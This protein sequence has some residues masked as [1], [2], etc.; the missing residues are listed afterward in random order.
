MHYVQSSTV[1]RI[2]IT[3]W[4]ILSPLVPPKCKERNKK[5]FIHSHWYLWHPL[6]PH[7][8]WQVSRTNHVLHFPW[9]RVRHRTLEL[10]QPYNIISTQAS[11]QPQ[12]TSPSLHQSQYCAS[13][14]V[15][16]L[17]QQQL[18]HQTIKMLFIRDRILPILLSHPDPFIKDMP[19]LH[20]VLRE[21]NSEQAKKNSTQHKCLP[22]ITSYHPAKKVLVHNPNNFDNNY[23]M[24]C[25]S[26]LFLWFLRSG[27]ITILNASAYDPPVHLKF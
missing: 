16:H 2:L 12:G 17:A 13:L 26:A 25:F 20:Y 18:K 6:S 8:D 9:N 15:S 21:I 11:A 24:I 10:Q 19:K 7:S 4:M 3:T 22:V 27:E 1:S 14:A 5:K 23:A